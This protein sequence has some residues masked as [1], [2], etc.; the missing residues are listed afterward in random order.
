MPEDRAIDAEIVAPDSVRGI[1]EEALA[2]VS[3]TERDEAKEVIA[4]RLKEIKR[5][6]TCLA[7]ARADLQELLKKDVSQIAL[8]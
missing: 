2:E 3:T 5:L 6:E 7:K 1:Y 4:K 8:L